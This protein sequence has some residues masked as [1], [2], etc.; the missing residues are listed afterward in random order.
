MG[1]H[2]IRLYEDYENVDLFITVL[3][4]PIDRYYSHL[5]HQL[6]RGIINSIEEFSND[7]F[8]N[9]FMCKRIS[10]RESAVDAIKILEDKKV[11]VNLLEID[12]VK[13]KRVNSS[14]SHSAEFINKELVF[15]RNK[16]DL[17][18]YNYFK[19][20]KST[21]FYNYF[22]SHSTST[23]SHTS[24]KLAQIIIQELLHLSDMNKNKSLKR[25]R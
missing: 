12:F 21:S 10:G 8:Y 16:E 6:E 15:E 7:P 2:R 19:E 11:L 24:Q 20:Q 5:S 18:L 14:N 3:R 4:N 17:M 1:G 25:G 13:M 22:K 9:N 23:L